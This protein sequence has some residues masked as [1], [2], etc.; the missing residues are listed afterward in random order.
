MKKPNRHDVS[1]HHSNS[2]E[3]SQMSQQYH[4]NSFMKVDKSVQLH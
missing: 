3:Y 2:I 1:D 4:T